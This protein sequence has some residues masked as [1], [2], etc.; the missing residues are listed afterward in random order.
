MENDLVWIKKPHNLTNAMNLARE[1]RC[2]MLLAKLLAIRKIDSKEEALK[3]LNPSLKDLIDPLN[4]ADMSLATTRLASAILNGEMIGIFGDYD[5][6]GVC[7]TALM[8]QFLKSIGANVAT[9]LPNRATEGCGLSN[10]GV[11]RLSA[12]GAKV[13]LSVDCGILAFAQI[14]YA[15]SQGF[16]VIIVDH[17]NVGDSLPKALAVINP[18][19]PDCLS[20]ADYL[21][22]AGVAF[23]LCIALRRH[24]RE[25]DFFKD[26]P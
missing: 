21:C 23:F 25:R 16:D 5:V 3:F 6:D 2:S 4:F 12:L 11:D 20:K 9:T 1:L 14:D 8:A 17:H 19:R 15:K 7:A 26:R 10:A 22:A 18:K 13:L 24:L